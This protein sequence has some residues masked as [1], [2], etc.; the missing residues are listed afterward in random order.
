IAEQHKNTPTLQTLKISTKQDQTR[1]KLIFH[2]PGE[3]PGKLSSSLELSQ[4]L[5]EEY[6]GKMIIE[7]FPKAK[8]KFKMII[9]LPRN[10]P[11]S[12]V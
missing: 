5:I 4:K 11:L 7:A 9:S 2:I 6:E 12:R 8:L 10:T 3:K 1:L